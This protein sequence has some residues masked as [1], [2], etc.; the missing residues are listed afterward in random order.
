MG[1]STTLS[2]LADPATAALCWKLFGFA[3]V[4]GELAADKADIG[5]FSINAQ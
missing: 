1:G 2:R 3:A 5:T 4:R